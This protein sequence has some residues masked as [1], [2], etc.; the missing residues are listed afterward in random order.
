MR[1]LYRAHS[2]SLS[3]NH[4]S[5]QWLALFRSGVIAAI[6]LEQ[7]TNMTEITDGKGLWRR[8]DRHLF[9]HGLTIIEVMVQRN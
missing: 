4:I 6:C 8:H 2:I 9:D 7:Q 3:G 5:K 1:G